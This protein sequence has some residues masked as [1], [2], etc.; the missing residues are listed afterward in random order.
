M[1][2]ADVKVSTIS[3]RKFTFLSR[4][5]AHFP[6]IFARAQIGPLAQILRSNWP[7]ARRTR[8]AQN[9]PNEIHTVEKL[10]EAGIEEATMMEVDL[11]APDQ[12]VGQFVAECC[13]QFGRVI[14][15]KVHRTPSPFALVEMTSRDQTHNLAAT[16]GGS[17]FGTSVLIHLRQKSA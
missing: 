14:S 2:V 17:T 5:S 15:V 13:A 3:C 10:L 6:R 9:Q 16:Y 8:A 12:R 4:N 11:G 7:N 1:F